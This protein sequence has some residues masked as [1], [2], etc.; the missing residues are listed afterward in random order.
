MAVF[1]ERSEMKQFKSMN[2]FILSTMGLWVLLSAASLYGQGC[3]MC[4]TSV[5]NSTQAKQAKNRLDAAILILLLPAATIF[6]GTFL[7]AYKYRNAFNPVGGADSSSPQM[8]VLSSPDLEVLGQELNWLGSLEL[9]KLGNSYTPS[10]A[11]MPDVGLRSG[12]E[13]FLNETITPQKHVA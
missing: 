2:K 10:P 11:R 7:V 13:P 4:Y 9:E 3:A 12:Q 8:E 5:A 6:A 1:F